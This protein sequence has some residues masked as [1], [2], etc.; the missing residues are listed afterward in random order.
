MNQLVN[1]SLY[2]KIFQNTDKD[3]MKFQKRF[4][5]NIYIK[6]VINNTNDTYIKNAIQQ[7]FDMNDNNIDDISDNEIQS[8]IEFLYQLNS[9]L[10]DDSTDDLQLFIETFKDLSNQCIPALKRKYPKFRLG[11]STIFV[12]IQNI[13]LRFKRTKENYIEKLSAISKLDN[14]KDSQLS[15]SSSS[16]IIEGFG[17]IVLSF[18]LVCIVNMLVGD[19]VDDDNKSDNNKRQN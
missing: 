11:I 1:G 9:C 14:F 6:K 13:L 2:G 8:K 12:S 19:V 17:Y 10:T 4:L 3:T 16:S 18:V 5:L 15:Q 7:L